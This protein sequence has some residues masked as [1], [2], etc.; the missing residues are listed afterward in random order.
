[1]AKRRVRVLAQVAGFVSLPATRG[2]NQCEPVL[3]VSRRS[4][5][6]RSQTP[7]KLA[8]ENCDDTRAPTCH[9]A[10]SAPTKRNGRE[11]E[12]NRILRSNDHNV[13]YLKAN[14]D[15]RNASCML[16]CADVAAGVVPI[17]RYRK[18]SVSRLGSCAAV[19][20][21]RPPSRFS[22]VRRRSTAPRA[23]P[24]PVIAKVTVNS[25]KSDYLSR[26]FRKPSNSSIIK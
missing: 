10:A 23:P 26:Y 18:C 2:N 12:P 20:A 7:G 17:R 13:L 25:A 6:A 9:A 15:S 4:P 24:A 8:T 21:V 11:L 5:P 14:D 16:L 3:A 19:S 1:M 22:S